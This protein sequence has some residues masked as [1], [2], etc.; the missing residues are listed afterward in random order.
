MK[1]LPMKSSGLKSMT[2]LAVAHAVLR[3]VSYNDNTLKKGK[4]KGVP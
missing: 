2:K 3:E 4:G 1:T